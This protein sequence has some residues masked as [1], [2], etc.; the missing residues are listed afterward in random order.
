MVCDTDYN[1]TASLHYFE[2]SHMLL[3]LPS[4][5][6][7]NFI[8]SRYLLQGSGVLDLIPRFDASLL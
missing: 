8:R 2:L 1:Y 5:L 6:D 7:Y 3:V 4:H